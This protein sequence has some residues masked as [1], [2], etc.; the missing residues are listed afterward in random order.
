MIGYIVMILEVIQGQ[1]NPKLHNQKAFHLWIV[2][3]EAY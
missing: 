1:A 2:Q 3:L